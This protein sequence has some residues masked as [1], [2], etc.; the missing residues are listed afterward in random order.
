MVA[1]A[2]LKA[3]AK[4]LMLAKRELRLP[5]ATRQAAGRT[6]CDGMAR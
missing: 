1:T 2:A 4:K 3:A 6:A 5:K